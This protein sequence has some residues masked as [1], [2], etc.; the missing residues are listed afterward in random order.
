MQRQTMMRQV[1]VTTYDR[2]GNILTH[3]GR[4][5]EMAVPLH[6]DPEV[7]REFREALKADENVLS[8]AER[9]DS[10]HCTVL[11]WKRRLG[12]SGQP[13][14]GSWSGVDE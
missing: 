1:G 13:H 3:W 12:F 10:D 14:I 5:I 8:I 2:D 11:Y 4:E 6:R 7:F 9:F